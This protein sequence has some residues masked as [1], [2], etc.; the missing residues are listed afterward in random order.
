MSIPATV[1]KPFLVQFQGDPMMSDYLIDLWEEGNEQGATGPGKQGDSSGKSVVDVSVKDSVDLGI[2]W[3]DVSKPADPRLRTYITHLKQ[4][5]DTYF[6]LYPW[7]GVSGM[8]DMLEG[9]NIQKYPVNGGFKKYHTETG[10]N[11]PNCWRTLVFMTYLN[12][13]DPEKGGQTS[14]FYQGVMTPAQK[15]TTLIWPAGLEWFHA[16]IPHETQEKIIATGWWHMVTPELHQ[17][18]IQNNYGE[19]IKMYEESQKQW[20]VSTPSIKTDPKIKSYKPE[21][22]VI[23]KKSHNN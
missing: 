23:L 18:F 16:G 14:F 15:S 13:C 7:H 5:L 20:T 21:E 8:Y 22:G 10:P 19:Q 2:H 4:C 11:A 9:F 12:D 17:E 3:M 6:E 1:I